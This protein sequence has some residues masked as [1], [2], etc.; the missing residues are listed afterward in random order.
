M[1]QPQPKAISLVDFLSWEQQQTD[2][3]EW[4]D[5]TVVRCGG[6]SYEHATIISN[7]NAVFHSAAGTGP[8]FVQG[9]D[10]KLV[11]RDL[12]GHDL[13]SF[14]ADI[15]VSCAAEDRKGNAAHL[16][17][18]VIEVL[19][20]HV[21][22]EFTH[23]KEAYLGSAQLLEY[24]IV[25][26]TRRYVVRYAWQ[27]TANGGRRL[28]TAEY[29]HGPVAMSTLGLSATFDTIYAGTNVS[30]ILHPTLPYDEDEAEILRD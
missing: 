28:L 1:N 20:A 16:P 4:I 9:S 21:G 24:L 22:Q 30:S 27:T 5:G 18:L 14:Y 17:A 19:S 15:F 29:R 13:G 26:S 12:N 11:P 23:K 25:D 6:G 8:C 3:Y 10:R 2:R 7:L